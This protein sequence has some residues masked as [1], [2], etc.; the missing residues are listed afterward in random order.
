MVVDIEGGNPPRAAGSFHGRD[1]ITI[2][3][4]RAFPQVGEDIF[5]GLA[6]ENLEPIAHLSIIRR[7]GR[8]GVVKIIE[9]GIAAV[10]VQISEGIDPGDIVLGWNTVSCP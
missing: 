6:G 9:Q 8:V 1:D 10:H 2:S 4:I 7:N 5:I 3:V